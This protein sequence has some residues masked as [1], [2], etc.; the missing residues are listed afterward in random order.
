MW[1]MKYK[2]KWNL[3]NLLCKI[4]GAVGHKDWWNN[5]CLTANEGYTTPQKIEKCWKIIAHELSFS[6]LLSL[7]SNQK[8]YFLQHNRKEDSWM[9]FNTNYFKQYLINAKCS[10]LQF[11]SAKHICK[12]ITNLWCN[13]GTKLSISKLFILI[14]LLTIGKWKIYNEREKILQNLIDKDKIK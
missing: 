12:M 3:Q 4:Q 10:E 14:Q 2:T 8:L 13:K 6:I 7:E 11:N 1:L 5:I 9:G